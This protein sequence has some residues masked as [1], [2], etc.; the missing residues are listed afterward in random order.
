MTDCLCSAVGAFELLAIW[1]RRA[2]PTISRLL[3]HGHRLDF[4]RMTKTATLVAGLEAGAADSVSPDNAE[5]SHHALWCPG[6]VGGAREKMPDLSK[7]P[8]LARPQVNRWVS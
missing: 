4:A 6:R 5:C 7:A 8:S 3:T 1:Q 2:Q